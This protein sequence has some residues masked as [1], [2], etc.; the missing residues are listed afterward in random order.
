[1]LDGTASLTPGKPFVLGSIYVPGTARQ[2]EIE[3]VA[4]LVR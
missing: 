2:Q 4:E 1:V 3:V